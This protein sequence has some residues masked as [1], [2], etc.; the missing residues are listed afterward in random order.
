[1]RALESLRFEQRISV[2]IDY[3]Y[4][5]V[6]PSS[7]SRGRKPLYLP[8]SSGRGRATG[9][10]L[11]RRQG[12]RRNAATG[13]E[14]LLPRAA[15]LPADACRYYMEV[16]RHVCPARP[17]RGASRHGPHRLPEP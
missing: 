1:M 5:I 11:Q 6:N 13:K 7:A 4:K 10:A 17:S 8:R 2:G 12:Q 3:D 9:N 16:P 14:G 15:T